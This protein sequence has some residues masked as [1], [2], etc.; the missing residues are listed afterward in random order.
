MLLA[1]YIPNLTF[2]FIMKQLLIGEFSFAKRIPSENV[3]FC[4]SIED[5]LKIMTARANSLAHIS[6]IHVLRFKVKLLTKDP[7]GFE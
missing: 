7:M 2:T 5:I 4:P 1:P 3:E 6:K